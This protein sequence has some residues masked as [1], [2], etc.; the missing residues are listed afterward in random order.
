MVFWY[1]FISSGGMAHTK[2]FHRNHGEPVLCSCDVWALFFCC[3]CSN[4][5]RNRLW[6]FCGS[7]HSQQ[8]ET[9]VYLFSQKWEFCYIQTC[10]PAYFCDCKHSNITINW[11]AILNESHTKRVAYPR[12][13]LQSELIKMLVFWCAYVCFFFFISFS[14]HWFNIHTW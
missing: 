7:I 6:V 12:Y 11:F 2:Y 10:M 3:C 13:S 14:Y 9:I 5:I 4:T 1:W 8:I